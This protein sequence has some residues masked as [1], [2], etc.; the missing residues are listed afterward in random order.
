MQLKSLLTLLLCT[1][2]FLSCEKDDGTGGGDPP[3]ENLG[4]AIFTVVNCTDVSVDPTCFTN[5]DVLAA[6]Q[7]FLY[8][9]EENREFNAPIY[10]EKT[11]GGDGT[12]EFLHLE[13][14]DYFYVVVYPL[15]ATV[16]QESAFSIANGSRSNVRIEFDEE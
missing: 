2:L 11:T 8:T 12:V 16:T 3:P 10:S 1:F 7:V 9:S 6:S 13:G 14:G 15:D 4:S 5:F